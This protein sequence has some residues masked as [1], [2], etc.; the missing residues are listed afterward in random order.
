VRDCTTRVG[1]GLLDDGIPDTF[2]SVRH[3]AGL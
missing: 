1:S 3:A 2:V